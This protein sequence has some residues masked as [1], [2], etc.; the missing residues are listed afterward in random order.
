MILMDDKK[1]F[2]CLE[3]LFP[4]ISMPI[5]SC[6]IHVYVCTQLKKYKTL[7]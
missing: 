7:N 4:S 1:Y 2:F 6:D 5:P 3:I